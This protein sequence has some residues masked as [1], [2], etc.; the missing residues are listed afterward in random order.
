MKYFSQATIIIALLCGV[1]LNAAV[2][3]GNSY[4]EGLDKAK[5]TN[6]LLIVLAHG[7]DW[8]SWGERI[9]DSIFN[10]DKFRQ[11][12]GK[13]TIIYAD[14]DILQSPSEEQKKKNDERNKL[15]KGTGVYTYPAICAYS[16]DGTLLGTCQGQK[17]PKDITRATKVIGDLIASCLRYNTLTGHAAKAKAAGDT[18]VELAALVQLGKLSLTRPAGLADRIKELDPKDAS[19]HYARFTFPHWNKLFLDST[20]RTK[21]GEALAVETELNE[22]LQNSAYSLEQKALVNVALATSHRQQKDHQGQ[23]ARY[24]K[25]AWG[26]SPDSFGG[27]VGKRSYDAWYEA[28]K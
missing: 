26:M 28:K 4:A 6:A 3:S 14:V 20:N 9:N 15:W 10:S 1:S 8:N 17:L 5:S 2:I 16:S 11:S 19:G 22:M 24:F 21:K 18:K 13:E 12:L 27:Q 23:A 7:S 25:Q